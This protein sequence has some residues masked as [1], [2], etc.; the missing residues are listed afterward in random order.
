MTNIIVSYRGILFGLVLIVCS[1]SLKADDTQGG[2]KTADL[3]ALSKDKSLKPVELTRG[4]V[5]KAV[6]HS[7][8][9]LSPIIGG[10]PAPPGTFNQYALILITDGNLRVT[11]IC[12]GSVIGDLK[13]LTAAQCALGSASHL[14]IFPAFYYRA[15]FILFSRLIAVERAAIH[16]KFNLNTLE[17]DVAVLTLAKPVPDFILPHFHNSEGNTPIHDGGFKFIGSAGESLGAGLSS[18]TPPTLPDRLQIVDAPIRSNFECNNSWKSATG[19]T[20]IKK[21]MMCAGLLD[22]SAGICNGDIGSPLYTIVKR[23][24]GA[25]ISSFRIIVGVASFAISPCTDNRGTQVFARV[26][27]LADFIKSESPR[28]AFFETGVASLAPVISLLLDGSE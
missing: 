7:Q 24:T 9:T 1:F 17:N 12:G 27:E 19:I 2:Y 21:S 3:I 6:I 18:I 25:V 10:S 5:E 13:I 26:G 11:N 28:S 8:D 14:F 22:R 20:P 4:P 23:R 16:P 15:E